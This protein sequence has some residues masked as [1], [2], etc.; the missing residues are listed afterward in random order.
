MLLK[1]NRI[2]INVD[3]LSYFSL[4]QKC[5]ATF[6]AIFILNKFESDR[7]G[8]IGRA[9]AL[10]VGVQIRAKMDISLYKM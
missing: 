4:L 9:F 2:K 5:K 8:A 6:T 10:H 1:Q 7:D 3:S